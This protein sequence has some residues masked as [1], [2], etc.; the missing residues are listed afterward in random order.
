MQRC[1]G[2]RRS[3]P[4]DQSAIPR[5]S[6]AAGMAVLRSSSGF[7]DAAVTT[8]LCLGV[9][10]PYASGIGGKGMLLYRDGKTGRIY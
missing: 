10:E 5:Q 8:S 9:A 1:T 2:N 7:V 3:T 4:N 6:S